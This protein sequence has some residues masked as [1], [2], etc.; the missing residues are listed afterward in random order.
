M[1]PFQ[2]AVSLTAH[3]PASRAA[4]SS[5]RISLLVALGWVASTWSG[6]GSP[7]DDADPPGAPSAEE[8]A[9]HG[10]A[11]DAPSAPAEAAE[12]LAATSD[13]DPALRDPDTLCGAAR[14]CCVFALGVSSG[15]AVARTRA[16]CEGLV[17]VTALGGEAAAAGCR[18]ALESWRRALG[19]RAAQACAIPTAP[20]S[21]SADT[22]SDTPSSAPPGEPPAPAQE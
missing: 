13:V 10:E 21:P 20:A 6:C 14:A 4:R 1:R 5:S 3:R 11:P 12:G 19:E 8:E 2:G 17:A 16:E 18:G 7:S 15:D 9:A 22:P